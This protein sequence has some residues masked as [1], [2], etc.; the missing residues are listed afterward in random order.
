MQSR[1][2]LQAENEA[3]Q[4]LVKQ[5]ADGS[6]AAAKRLSGLKAKYQQLSQKVLTTVWPFRIRLCEGFRS[7]HYAKSAHVHLLHGCRW[8]ACDP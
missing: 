4:D 8:Q 2:G 5:Q 6:A 1:F 7:Q 3:L